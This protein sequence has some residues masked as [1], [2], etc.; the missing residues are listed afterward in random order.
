[1][2]AMTSALTDFRRSSLVHP[3]GLPQL[4]ERIA[5][6]Y[7][8][9]HSVQV[10]PECIVVSV[11]TSMAFR[12][13]HQ[14]LVG[15]GDE[16]L[17]PRPYYPLYL[18]TARLAGAD[19]RFYD[20]DLASMRVGLESL[21]A[22]MSPRTRVVVV[23]SPGNPLGNVIS[24]EDFQEIDLIV[25][26]RAVIISDEI[27]ANVYFDDPG[28]SALEL[29]ELRSPLIVTNAFSKAHRMYARRVGYAV[30]PSPLVDP[31]TVIQHHTL[32]T[33]DPVPQ[34]GAVAALD[35]Q[36]GVA[37]LVQLYRSRRDYTMRHL[38]KIGGIEPLP[39]R[40][41]F[42]HTLDCSGYLAQHGHSSSL[43][44][45]VSVLAETGVATVPGSDFGA[46]QTLRLSYTS[47]RYHEAV[48]RLAGF[49]A[50]GTGRAP[51]TRE[52]IARR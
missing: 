26:G 4:K 5:E 14:L 44:L 43:E 19:I 50:A 12:N 37:E 45:A 20:I 33:T 22:A 46:G 39:S 23:N 34:F 30:V 28:Y 2:D 52:A 25:N 40:G 3:A 31:L 21:A 8:K 42:Y 49:F 47:A 24:R 6:E 18:F 13:L 27:Y 48:D 16:V 10:P 17:L 29:P 35:N 1:M 36:D 41:G 32:L 9:Q 7:A 51:G 11:G 15:P 38:A